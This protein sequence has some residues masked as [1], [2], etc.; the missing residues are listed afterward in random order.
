MLS[1]GGCPRETCLENNCVITAFASTISSSSTAGS[2]KLIDK[3]VTPFTE[4]VYRAV[5]RNGCPKSDW[6]WTRTKP[7]SS[8]APNVFI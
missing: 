7:N 8:I 2:S 1:F 3:S 5:D 6:T 4:Y